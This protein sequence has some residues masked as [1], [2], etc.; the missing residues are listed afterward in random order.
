MLDNPE[1]IAGVVE[2]FY[3]QP[4]SRTERLELFETLSRSGLNTYLYAP[5]DD[6]KHRSLW[7]ETYTPQEAAALAELIQA[8]VRLRI[9][10]VYAIAPGLDIQYSNP[11]ELATLEERLAQMLELGC[12]NFALLFDDLPDRMQPADAA[13]YA[14]FASAQAH[15][16][17]A[18]FAWTRARQASGRFFFCPTPYCGRM[19][20]RALGGQ[21]YLEML[22]RELAPEIHIFWTGPEIISRQITR[23]HLAEVSAILRRKPVLWE[24][25]YANDYD[26]RRFFCGPYDGRAPEIKAAVSGILINPNNE[27]PLNFIPFRSFADFVH[28][29]G[30]WNPRDSYLR[31]MHEWL[32]HFQ[33]VHPPPFE[34]QDLVAF[35]DCYY[36]PHQ[37][38]PEAEALFDEAESLVQGRGSEMGRVRR[39]REFC[40]RLPEITDRPLFYAL[41]RRVWDLREELDLLER[42]AA[43]DPHIPFASDFHL[44]QT[45]RGGFVPRL[46]RLLRQNPDGTFT[47]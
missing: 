21:G 47:P 24:N 33:P 23:E 3:G 25:L 28:C 31:A 8:C 42:F 37:D 2:G 27:F 18:L 40:T 39:L 17:N 34:L 16:A 11:A 15:I 43:R 44:P 45:Y 14:S 12:S 22:G 38:G 35:G 36:L 10:F 5:K 6:L 19:A 7:R 46:Q 29:S 1:L 20:E 30:S 32:A 4:W 26:G 9:D 41:S 13:R